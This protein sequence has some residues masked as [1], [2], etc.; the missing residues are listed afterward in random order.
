MPEL[1]MSYGVH[2]VPTGLGTTFGTK[3]RMWYNCDYNVSGFTSE[4][5]R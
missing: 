5:M 3:L 2:S 4:H 1:Q